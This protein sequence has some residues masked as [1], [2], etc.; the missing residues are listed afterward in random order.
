MPYSRVL[1][2]GNSYYL[3]DEIDCHTKSYQMKLIAMLK[4]A[5]EKDDTVK[6]LNCLLISD[7]G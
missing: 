3:N 2:C 7:V 6:K 1:L 5:K 4:I